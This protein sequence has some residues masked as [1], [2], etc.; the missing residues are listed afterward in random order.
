M[1]G[2][3]EAGN[4]L[5]LSCIALPNG[6]DKYRDDKYAIK[7]QRC[8]QLQAWLTSPCLHLQP[9]LTPLYKSLVTGH[10]RC[11]DG[12]FFRPKGMAYTHTHTFY[13]PLLWKISSTIKSRQNLHKPTNAQPIPPYP[14]SL[15]LCYLEGTPQHYIISSIKV[16]VNISKR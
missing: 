13:F 11:L 5:Q 6:R 4:E 9:L 2:L 16:L 10:F 8:P 3:L 15:F 7:E 14:L 1:P 12:K